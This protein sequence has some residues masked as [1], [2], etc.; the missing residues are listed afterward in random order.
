[1]KKQIIF[2]GLAA[3]LVAS[4]LTLFPKEVH[5]HGGTRY[6]P[7]V[8]YTYF[9]DGHIEVGQSC[10]HPNQNGACPNLLMCLPQN[11]EDR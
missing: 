7:C 6:D 2:F 9:S 1:M 11:E 3:L 5:A 10:D 8:C 4:L